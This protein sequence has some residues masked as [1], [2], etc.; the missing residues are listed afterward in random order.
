L[1]NS[2]SLAMRPAANWVRRAAGAAE[3]IEACFSGLAYAPHSHET[4]TLALTTDGVQSFRYRGELRSS[5]P[6]HVVVLHPD[7]THDGQAGSDSPFA[8]RAISIDPAAVQDVLG[9][10][11]LP[12]LPDGVNN[13]SSLVQIAC[14]LLADMRQPLAPLEHQELVASFATTLQTLTGRSVKHTA[15]NYTAIKRVRDYI[16]DM[17]AVSGELLLHVDLDALAAI[18]QYSKWQVTRDFRTLYG[19]TPYRYIT[20]KRL[21]KARMLIEHGRSL[22]LV[23]AS[24]GFADQSHLSRQFKSSF[25][26]TPGAW[27]TLRRRQTT[28]SR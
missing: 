26:T 25:G 13:A 14:R 5:L 28:A 15:A 7:E 21:Q 22:A 6:G 27:A 24:T 18:A 3:R 23:A 9:G 19:T 1:V 2:R 17:M 10:A 8:Y 12:F 4:Y 20:L 11:C 16:D